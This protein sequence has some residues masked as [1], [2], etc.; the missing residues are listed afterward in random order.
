MEQ[1]HNE[2][3]NSVTLQYAVGGMS[4]TA[5][6]ARIEKAVGKMEGVQSVAVSYP[7]R[8]AWVQFVPGRIRSEDVMAKIGHIGF[9]ASAAEHS[10]EQWKQERSALGLRLMI[11]LLLTLPLLAGMTQHLPL[12]SGLSIPAWLLHPWLQLALATIVQFVIGLPFY[13]GAYHAL[14]SRAA[15]MD[16]L[17]AAGTSAAYLY[18]HYIVFSR[19]PT[20]ETLVAG[21]TLPLYFETSA[22][23]I[24]AVL[25]G[26]YLEMTAASRAQ[27]EAGGYSQLQVQSATVERSGQWVSVLTAF[28]WEG[29][30]V[31]IA[32]GETV[33]VDGVLTSGETDMDESL[34]TGESL[35]VV[36]RAG[37]RIWAGTTNVGAMQRIRTTAAGHA[38]L[39]S[40]ISELL[41]QAQRSK[42][43]IQQQVDRVAA[44]F[45]PAMLA[46]SAFTFMLWL[47][48]LEPGNW[49]QAFRCGV[50]V[51]LAAC[52]CALG[53]AA[54]ISLVIASGRLAKLG[55]VLKQAGAL[56]RLARLNTL[57]LDKTGTLTEGTP[58]VSA[59]WAAPTQTR[60]VVLRLA[61]AA[62]A[63]SAH[64][65][66]QA[67]GREAGR[68][69]LTPPS[70]LNMV[71][72]PGKGVQAVVEG[73]SIAVG[74]ATFAKA[75]QWKANA[76][77]AAAVANF[78]TEREKR[79]E[80]LLYVAAD[81][82][83]I[84]CI[85]LADRVKPH[86]FAAVQQLQRYGLQVML[87]TGD[88]QIP[89]QNAARQAGITQVY[90]GLLPEQKLELV[91]QLKRSGKRVGMAGDGWNDAPALAAAD[92]GIAMGNGT[93]A[94]LAAGH[95]TLLQPRMTAIVDALGISRLTVRNIKQNLL[96]AFLYNSSI[97]P[98]A[99][100]GLLE[101]WMAG[102]AMA[103]SSVSV[104]GNAM[105]LSY[106]LRR[107]KQLPA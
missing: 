93:E 65:L 29:E 75:E 52:P 76:E 57:L 81:G 34:L 33:P 66:G 82:L 94:A 51:M 60:S 72:F 3:E 42:S 83:L 25:L 49:H 106:I 54:P 50:A 5:C 59:V 105:R 74:N 1:R 17:V 78:C 55:I 92:V 95:L 89:A 53:L 7:A 18:S 67:I 86:S 2:S 99:A 22:V 79:G 100:F 4:C 84:G 48:L 102:A 38:T 12:L 20:G 21:H 43:A 63:G 69:G 27:D 35:P 98:F 56:E 45:V 61:A 91:E 41:R 11:S 30:I 104:V 107:H 46:L 88:H 15:N 37:D 47:V 36:K 39:L 10:K 26:K 14:R 58:Q 64:P 77:A 16:V 31:R 96:L 101:P 23:V 62:E 73:R 87:A 24:S 13:I 85:S 68:V 40:R 44:W 9:Q 19:L 6:A 8:S 90:A 32:P 103:L 70:A 71:Y 80:T 28:I 97:V